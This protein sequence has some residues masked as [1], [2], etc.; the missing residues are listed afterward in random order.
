MAVVGRIVRPH[1]LR[2]HVIVN[3]ETDFPEERFRDGSQLFVDRGGVVEPLTLTAVRF[4][5]SRP[6]LG[7]VGI[8]RIEDAERLVG[9]ELRI[10]AGRLKRLPA[11]MFYRHDLAGCRVE[12]NVG[13]DIGI[14]KAVEGTADVSR[15]VVESRSGE[16]ILI[17]LVS[18]IC[19]VID[20]TTKRIVIDPPLGLLDLNKADK[21]PRGTKEPQ[22][23]PTFE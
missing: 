22:G 18:E 11:G 20:T 14:V 13:A 19:V 10:P 17:P 21:G 2:G 9:L 23:R 16:E 15:L 5:Q 3:I 12:T 8:E 6:I 7:F 4:H 1:G